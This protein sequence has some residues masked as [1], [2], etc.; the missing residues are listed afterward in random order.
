MRRAQTLSSKI[1]GGCPP[2]CTVYAVSKG[3]LSSLRPSDSKSIRSMRDYGSDASCFTRDYSS[4]QTG[5]FSDLRL[6]GPTDV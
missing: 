5:I 6:F 4:S 2:F 1:S 3:K